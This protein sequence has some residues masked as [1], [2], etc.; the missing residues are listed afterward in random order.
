MPKDDNPNGHTPKLNL[1][2]ELHFERSPFK[3][4]RCNRIFDDH[5]IVE[6]IESSKQLRV[7][8]GLLVKMELTCMHC[9][10][11]HHWDAHKK[12]LEEIS[13]TYGKMVKKSGYK[14][15]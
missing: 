1:P 4:K 2:E 12:I 11:V 3:C 9:G 14:A 15:E 7:G 13:V 5:L 6:E 10:C 8:F